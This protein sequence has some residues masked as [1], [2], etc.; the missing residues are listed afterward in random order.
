M[1]K[2]EQY[3]KRCLELAV[4]GA[5]TVS[6]NPMV[7]AVIVC[8]NKIIGEGYTSPYGGAHAEVNA[9]QNAIICLGESEAKQLFKKS[10][11]YVSLEPCAHHGKTPPCADMLV[12]YQFQ[13]V[14]VGCLDSF[15]NGQKRKMVSLLQLIQ[16]K[17]GFRMLRVNSWFTNGVR[18]KMLF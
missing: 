5:G 17:N 8:D 4:L 18:K 7:G 10:T 16:H 2:E 13:K 11:I 15:A 12:S 1:Q 9:V 14:V 3:I 6:P